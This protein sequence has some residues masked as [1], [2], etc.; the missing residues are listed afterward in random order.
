MDCALF[1]LLDEEK[2]WKGPWT[3]FRKTKMRVRNNN[4]AF[5][6]G[7]CLGLQWFDISIQ[8]YEIT[9]K[10]TSIAAE[11]IFIILNDY[12]V[13]PIVIVSRLDQMIENWTQIKIT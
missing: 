3:I 1:C 2:S 5:G 10:S 6:L 7:S 9:D 11:V 13:I 8:R 4:W 12:S